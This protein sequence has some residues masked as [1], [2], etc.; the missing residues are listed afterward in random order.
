MGYCATRSLL[1][2]AVAALTA[3]KLSLTLDSQAMLMRAALVMDI[4]MARQQDS[5]ACQLKAPSAMQR[6]II[7]THASISVAILRGF[8]VQDPDLLGMVLWH[9]EPEAARGQISEYLN[10]D[11]LSLA[12][13]LV[14]KMAPRFSRSAMSSL[15]A[16]KALVLDTNALNKSLRTAMASVLGFYPPGTYVQLAN[17]E[18]AVVISR[19]ERATTPHVA[20]LINADGMPLNTYLYRDT[21]QEGL[22][23]RAPVPASRVNIKVSVEKVH[24]L[25][26]QRGV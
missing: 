8:G 4:G 16:A 15:G 3:E 22:A 20:C 26:Y 14:A 5:L 11:L 18:L 1:C 2:G 17:G 10:L 25:R 9:H 19:G 23:V 13:T 7:Q 6:N 12:D 24:R 21:R